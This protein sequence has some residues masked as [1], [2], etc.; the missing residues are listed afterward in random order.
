MA[1]RKKIRIYS[2]GCSVCRDAVD[3]VERLAGTSHDLE[4]LDMQQVS[5]A[6]QAKR[7][8]VRSVPSVVI[9]AQIAPLDTNI[10]VD[11][12]K[13]VE[14]LTGVPQADRRTIDHALIRGLVTAFF[15]FSVVGPPLSKH[16][17][18]SAYRS[19]PCS[20]VVLDL[21]ESVLD[22]AESRALGEE[23]FAPAG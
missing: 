12:T 18:E 14:N 13:M 11:V 7:Q 6:Q 8:G 10:S 1:Q 16:G 2:A 9:D 19:F 3:M 22:V 15:P 21:L 23:G 20:R 5:V 17:R 4:I